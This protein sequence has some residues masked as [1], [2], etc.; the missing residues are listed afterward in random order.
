MRFFFDENTIAVGRVLAAARPDVAVSG[1]GTVPGTALGATDPEWLETVARSGLMVITRDGHIRTRP[2][3][4]EALTANGGRALVLLDAG[5][6][7]TWQLVARLV[8][9]WQIIDVLDREPGPWI[10][11]LRGRRI[12]N[13]P[14]S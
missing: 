9:A 4:R 2:A 8:E 3:E 12:T 1:D 6:A 13:L 7:T 14:L 11:G 5:S 10:K